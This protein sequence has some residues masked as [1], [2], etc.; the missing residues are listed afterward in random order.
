MGSLSTTSVDNYGTGGFTEVFSGTMR[1]ET[2]GIPRGGGLPHE[3]DYVAE[4]DTPYFYNPQEG[5]LLVE[6]II[7]FDEGTSPWN[8]YDGDDGTG[9]TFV[10]AISADAEEASFPPFP[11][12]DVM[13][14]TVIPEPVTLQAGDA[15]KDLD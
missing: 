3:F 14:C 10:F 8:W 6:L 1:F 2:D 13:K 15:D 12:L 11:G 9:S 7:T 4:F 5:N